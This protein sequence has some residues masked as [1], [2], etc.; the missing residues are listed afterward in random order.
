MA[1][2]VT[3]TK[4]RA[5]ADEDEG[6]RL[7]RELI[8]LLNEL[9]V[10]M[11][12]VQVL[13]GF[14][15]TVPFQQRFETADDFQRAVYFVT[16]LL[17]AASAAFLMA[18]SAFH[19]LTFREGQKPYLIALGTRHAIVGTALLALAMNGA[20][21]LL[22][23]VLFHSLTVAVTVAAMSALFGWLW[24]GLAWRRKASGKKEW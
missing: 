13:F 22:T 18:P 23:D 19:R 9:R 5:R 16:L 2:P 11:P 10:V 3:T 21:L 1:D 8:E 7:D 6:E 14:L 15:L 24:F 20:I 12:G 4:D 17:T